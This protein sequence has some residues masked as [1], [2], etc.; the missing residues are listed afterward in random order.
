M[1]C[2]V[3]AG[4]GSGDLPTAHGTLPSMTDPRLSV[5]LALW[6]SVN[7]TSTLVSSPRQLWTVCTSEVPAS[8][9]GVS[10]LFLALALAHKPSNQ[11]VG[12]S[13]GST[14]GGLDVPSTQTVYPLIQVSLKGCAHL[15]SDLFLGF[16]HTHYCKLHVLFIVFYFIFYF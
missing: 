10:C 14:A 11:P 2:K 3:S 9:S 12:T 6:V 8:S 7:L 1:A 13:A 15:S 16:I 5:L 4:P